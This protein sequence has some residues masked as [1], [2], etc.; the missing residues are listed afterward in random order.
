MKVWLSRDFGS[1][2]SAL[3]DQVQ[4]ASWATVEMDAGNDLFM[5]QDDGIEGIWCQ[6]KHFTL[7]DH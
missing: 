4:Q 2:W 7:F 5:L 1:T 6:W 3:K